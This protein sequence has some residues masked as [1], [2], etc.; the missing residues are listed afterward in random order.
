MIDN[1]I[2]ADMLARPVREFRGRVEIYNGSTLTQICGCH[3][4]LQSFTIERAGETKFFG[5]GICQKLNVKLIDKDRKMNVSTDN[6]LEAV[7]GAGN[8]YIYAFPKFNVS[9]VHRDENN[10]ELSITAY[11]DLYKA[12]KHKVKELVLGTTYTVSEFLS[13]CA[14]LLNLP[15][16]IVNIPEAALKTEYVNGANFDGEETVREALTAV[17]EAIQSIFY[18]NHEWQLTFRRLDITGAS[19]FTIGKESYISLESGENRRLSKIAHVTELG[20]NVAVTT[21]LSGTTQYVRN[22]P[23][24]EMRE[25]IDTLLNNAIAAVGNLTINQ[26]Y[27]EWRGNFLLEIGDKI[28]LVTKDNKTVS[29]YLLN[30]SISFDGSLSEV[31]EW[32]YEDNEEESEENPVSLGDA[33]KQTFARVDKAN[34]N[35]ELLVSD[36]EGNKESI[37][38]LQL[39]AESITASVKKLETSTSESVAGLNKDISTLTSQVETKMSAEDVQI[40]IQTELA[41][42]VDKVVTSTGFTFNEDGLT[43]SKTGSEMTTTITEDGMI[44]YRDNEA[45]LTANNIGV[46]AVN[47]HAT[48]YLIIGSNSRLEDYETNRTGCFWIGGNS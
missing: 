16:N 18:I 47:L 3:D 26:F 42:G 40:K 24:W 20:D 7:F 32:Q 2:F 38:N 23:F 21:G 10:N 34:K 17:A 43:V 35:I 39:D 41:N 8:N 36:N 44:V 27:C 31:T 46:D 14:N 1:A 28:D 37:T 6:Y 9:E 5:Y 19:A 25:D 12:N 30:D 4:A 45:V 15:L 11:D 33:L 13:A 48:T 22:N 29:S